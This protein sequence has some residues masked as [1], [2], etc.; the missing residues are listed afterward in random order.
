MSQFLP[1]TS[2]L[3]FKVNENNTSDGN[4]QE[5]HGENQEEAPIIASFGGLLFSEF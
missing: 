3:I 5:Q 2:I 1:K 4:Y